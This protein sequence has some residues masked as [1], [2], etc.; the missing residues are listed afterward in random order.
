MKRKK[1]FTVNPMNTKVLRQPKDFSFKC[2][3]HTRSIFSYDEDLLISKT[4]EYRDSLILP[5]S[6]WSI[7]AI[8]HLELD[9]DSKILDMCCAPGMKL[10]YAGLLLRSI[11]YQEDQEKGPYNATG[12]QNNSITGIDISRDRLSITRS[13]VK[14]YKVPNIR[15]LHGDASISTSTPVMQRMQ[16]KESTCGCTMGDGKYAPY[17]TSTGLRRIGHF[18]SEKYN[19]I[20]VDPECTQTSTVKYLE[21]KRPP[22]KEYSKIQTRI[23]NHALSMLEPGGILVYST[24]TFEEAENEKVVENILEENKHIVRV[25]I[26]E[27]TKSKYQVSTKNIKKTEG[28]EP[29]KYSDSLFIAKLKYVK[30]LHHIPQN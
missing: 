4:K 15:L 1:F 26:E 28:S 20:V 10:V 30:H 12:E 11:A 3:Q 23:L 8:D 29:L 27:E 14:K 2:M 7:I 13:L 21:G 19:R 24:C 18:H 22:E 16:K 5:M 6:L 17:Y 9:K 25:S